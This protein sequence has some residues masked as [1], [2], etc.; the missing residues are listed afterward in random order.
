MSAL[1]AIL[2]LVGIVFYAVAEWFDWSVD[3]TPEN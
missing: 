1:G 3:V 2:I